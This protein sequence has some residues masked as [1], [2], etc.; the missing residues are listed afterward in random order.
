MFYK[1]INKMSKTTNKVDGPSAPVVQNTKTI[2][3]PSAYPKQ[4]MDVV[5]NMRDILSIRKIDAQSLGNLRNE[6]MSSREITPEI[7]KEVADYYRWLFGNTMHYA[8]CPSCESKG[9]NARVTARQAFGTGEEFVLLDQ[10]DDTESI[11]PC[12]CCDNKMQLIYDPET[13]VDNFNQKLRGSEESFMSLLRRE[14][15]SIAGLG[16]GYITNFMRELKLEWNKYPYMKKELQRLE[17]QRSEE[18]FLACLNQIYGEEHTGNETVFA[19]NC[20]SVAPDAKGK[21]PTVMRNLFACLTPEQLQLKILGDTKRGAYAHS[22]LRASGLKDGTIL[23]DKGE[24]DILIGGYVSEMQESF[25]LPSEKFKKRRVIALTE[26]NTEMAKEEANNTLDGDYEGSSEDW[27]YLAKDYDTKVLSI[28]KTSEKRQR[29]IDAVE[30]EGKILIVGCGSA[31]YLQE[32][33]LLNR[34]VEIIAT[35]FNKEML[36]LSQKNFQHPNLQHRCVDARELPEE[37]K[38]MFNTVI[39]TNS[40]IPPTRRDI[41]SIYTS[42]YQCLK[43]GGQFLA[44]LPSYTALQE[45]VERCPE[46]GE[47]YN[48][49]LDNEQYRFIDTTGWQCFHT[50]QLIFHELQQA[51]FNP[52]DILIEKIPSESVAESEDIARI[53]GSKTVSKK[54]WCFFVRAQKHTG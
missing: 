41:I 18:R 38:S 16:F 14:D 15:D 3:T 45:F 12:P 19:C 32:D 10:L 49:N 22:I 29:I 34:N 1:K 48:K 52:E 26:I 47:M 5:R 11:A 43:N 28:T 36:A 51:G 17:Y 6:T 37:F 27:S 40:I 44:Y 21:L 35:D 30:N 4:Q 25:C 31:I 42:I 13:I 23:F 39:S 46:L 7:V 50:K 20:M 33:L 54:Y 24:E 53:Y 2:T 9:L 8:V